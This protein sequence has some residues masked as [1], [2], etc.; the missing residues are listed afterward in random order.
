M[1]N[2][3]TSL[4]EIASAIAVTVGAAL[5]AAPLGWIAGGVLGLAFARGLA[6]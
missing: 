3:I 4:V 6:R 1:R 5:V 2:T